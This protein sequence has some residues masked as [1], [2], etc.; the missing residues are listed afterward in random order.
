MYWIELPRGNHRDYARRQFDV[1]DRARATL[2]HQNATRALAEERMPA[3]VDNHILPD[4]G[5]MT[6]QLSSDE[7]PGSSV[8]RRP[9]P[10]PPHV[11]TASLSRRRPT[12]S[13]STTT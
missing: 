1:C 11:S 5:T 2:L 3:I 4:M 10:T 7:K 12:A 8:T 6:A 9:A 13:T